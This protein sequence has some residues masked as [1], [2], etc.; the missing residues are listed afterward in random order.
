VPPIPRGILLPLALA[1][2]CAA[3]AVE[4]RGGYLQVGVRGT[5]GLESGTGPELAPID[6]E[7]ELGL[8]TAGAPF[9]ELVAAGEL[10][11]LTL[12][13]FRYEVS[14]DGVIDQSFGTIDPGTRVESDLRFD[15]LR[16]AWTYDLVDTEHFR[17]GPGLGV[18]WFAIDT[19]VRSL[20]AV[21]A[22]ERIEV[23]A[24][25]PMLFARAEARV[26]RFG[27]DLLAGGMAVDAGEL[28]GTFWDLEG[29]LTWAPAA[30][31]EF[32]AGYRRIDLDARGVADAERYDADI[33]VDGWTLGAALRF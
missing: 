3:P 27:L 13:G 19:S 17:L 12:S 25:V 6:V 31:I 16:A 5:V 22:Y 9:A 1:A 18:D 29:R 30:S 7:D 33:V 20:T 26:G 8:G 4:V 32:F 15:N 2:A 23:Q 11:R 28:D 14:G 21:S 24:P 10:G